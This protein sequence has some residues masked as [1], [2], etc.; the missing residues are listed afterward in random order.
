MKGQDILS[1]TKVKMGYDNLFK[2]VPPFLLL[3]K[4]MHLL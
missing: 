1:Q 3:A 2:A 4:T